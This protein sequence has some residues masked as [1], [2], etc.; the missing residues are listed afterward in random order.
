MRI[1][2]IDDDT[3]DTEIFCE[4]LAETFPQAVCTVK[5]NC[6]NM[7]SFLEAIPAQDVIFI[8]GHLNAMTGLDCLKQ[9]KKFIAEGTKIVVHTGS[10]SPAETQDLKSAGIDEILLK[11]NSYELL[12]S[13]LKKLLSFK[14]DQVE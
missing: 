14:T 4:A 11:A 12:K 6:D 2:I 8:D 3:D 7:I 9:I 10:L 13:N 5:N 1:L